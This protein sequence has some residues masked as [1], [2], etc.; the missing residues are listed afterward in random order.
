MGCDIH[1]IAESKAININSWWP[2]AE[3]HLPRNYMIFGHMADGL[4]Y[5]GAKKP[6]PLKGFPKDASYLSKERYYMLLADLTDKEIAEYKSYG[7][8]VVDKIYLEHPDWH[9]ASWLS[10][11]ELSVALTNAI[12]DD[13]YLIPSE[14]IAL[15]EFMQAIDSRTRVVFWFDN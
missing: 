1:L 8:K 7:S 9:S 12:G 10:L 2:L 11:S 3:F 15:V 13:D 6:F 4:R 14:Y 5:S